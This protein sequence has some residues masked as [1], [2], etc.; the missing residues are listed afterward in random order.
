MERLLDAAG[1]LKDVTREDSEEENE[2]G[3]GGA[4]VSGNE[5]RKRKRQAARPAVTGQ[6][7]QRLFNMRSV[8][9]PAETVELL[10]VYNPDTPSFNPAL[11]FTD[12]YVLENESLGQEQMELAQRFDACCTF[13][14]D[15]SGRSAMDKFRRLL[16][17]LLMFDIVRLVNPNAKGGRVG[18]VMKSEI[19]SMLTKIY[20]DDPDKALTLFTKVN[21][22]CQKGKKLNGLWRRLGPACLVYLIE[23][24]SKDL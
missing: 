18:D 6:S 23:H 22:W 19:T 12:A 20:P 21:E 13:Q 24:L 17:D 11:F 2:N 1:L 15:I 10:R 9:P 3:G 7:M 4:A 16:T 5:G 8:A 14:S